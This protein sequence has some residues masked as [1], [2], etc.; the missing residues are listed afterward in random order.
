MMTRLKVA[1][2]LVILGV[3]VS[4]SGRLYHVIKHPEWT[5]PQA[6][7]GIWPVWVVALALIVSGYVLHW[8]V[9]R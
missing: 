2:G 9:T 1:Y 3:L 5:E 6:L 8:R 4:L 7:L